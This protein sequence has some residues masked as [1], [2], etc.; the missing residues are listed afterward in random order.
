MC[1]AE[2]IDA[3]RRTFWRRLVCMFIP[4]EAPEFLLDDIP[5]LP[6]AVVKEMIPVWMED[7]ALDIRED[8]VYRQSPQGELYRVHE[9]CGCEK[10][11]IDQYS[12]G[13][14][15]CTIAD[16]VAHAAGLPR[17]EAFAVARRLFEKLCEHG[18]CHP[19]DAH[20]DGEGD[21]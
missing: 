3:D 17:S 1:D 9:F 11:M 18:W 16:N 4:R 5:K 15:L 20:F 12:R 13:L 6:D 2:R 19:A 21:R 7:A 10:A 14:N 8:G